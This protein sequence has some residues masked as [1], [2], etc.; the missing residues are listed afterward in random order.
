MRNLPISDDERA[1]LE[2]ALASFRP[3]RGDTA[4]EE[5]VARR[6]ATIA[7]DLAERVRVL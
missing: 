5:A 1:V 7:K 4:I 6:Q 2:L 3:E